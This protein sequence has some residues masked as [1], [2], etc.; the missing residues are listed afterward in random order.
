MRFVICGAGGVGGCIGADLHKTGHS[1]TLIARGDHYRALRTR[2]LWIIRVHGEDQLHIPV[3]D[4]PRH[5]QW[6]GDEVVLLTMKSQHTSD[7]LTQLRAVNP[8]PSSS[9]P[10]MG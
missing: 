8:G 5:I 3:V 2:G 7:A 4:H 9:A 1:V 6:Q 10:R